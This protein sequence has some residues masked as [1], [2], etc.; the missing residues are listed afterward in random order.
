MTSDK[1]KEIGTRISDRRKQLNY[2]QEQIADKMDVSIQMISNL[3]RGN[4]AIK[5]ENLIK[6]SEILNVS[7]DYILIGKHTEKDVNSVLNRISNLSDVDYKMI[8]MLIEYCL[9]K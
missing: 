2:T 6:I 9:N 7:T 8:D 4:K 1:L 5:I 3:E